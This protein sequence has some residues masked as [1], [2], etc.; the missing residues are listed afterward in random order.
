[1][2]YNESLFPVIIITGN[3]GSLLANPVRQS[4]E[5]SLDPAILAHGA[6]E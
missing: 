1:L 5:R 3:S 6:T 4:I 2:I